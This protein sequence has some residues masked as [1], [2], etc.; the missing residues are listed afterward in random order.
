[1]ITLT[2]T[3]ADQPSGE[4]RINVENPEQRCTTKE[5]AACKM[6]REA[7]LEAA[8]RLALTS[9]VMRENG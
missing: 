8:V 6:V 9:P 3:I 7:I 4:T 5:R 1:M 2:I